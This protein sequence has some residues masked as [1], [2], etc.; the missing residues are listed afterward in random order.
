MSQW[1]D[2]EQIRDQSENPCDESEYTAKK[3]LLT[4]TD[5]A[6]HITTC[7]APIDKLECAKCDG[8][9]FNVGVAQWTT[10]IRCTTCGWELTVHEG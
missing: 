9:D 10:A 2:G 4:R 6:F 8:D 3:R 5:E 7:D 1:Y